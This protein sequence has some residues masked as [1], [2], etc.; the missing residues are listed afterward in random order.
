MNNDDDD[1]SFLDVKPEDIVAMPPQEK[2]WATI[3]D[4]LKL[5]YIDWSM[6]NLMALQFDE[7]HKQGL[8][9]SESHVICKLMTLVRD[10]VQEETAAKIRAEYEHGGR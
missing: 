1:V 7:L 5:Q 9:K 3:G 8:E 10:V 2:V 4:D 6:I